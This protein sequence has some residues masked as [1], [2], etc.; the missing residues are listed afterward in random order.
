MVCIFSCFFL[1]V[2]FK[3]GII[4]ESIFNLDASSKNEQN[5]YPS[6]FYL[7]LEVSCL[8]QKFISILWKSQTFCARRKDDLHSVKL[9]FVQAQVF[10]EALNTVKF[11]GWLKKFGPAQNI[12]RPVK[13]QGIAYYSPPSIRQRKRAPE[14]YLSVLFSEPPNFWGPVSPPLTTAQFTWIVK[15]PHGYKC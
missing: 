10:E 4:S 3:G 5:N 1:V 11:F 7:G 2:I 6:T 13:G 9:F 14:N 15:W 12:L 8:V